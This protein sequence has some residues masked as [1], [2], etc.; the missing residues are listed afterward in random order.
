M[1]GHEVDTSVCMC[2]YVSVCVCDRVTV[3]IGSRMIIMTV[4]TV[5]GD[6][7]CVSVHSLIDG[8]SRF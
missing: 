7:E 2:M 4:I 6:A 8:N 3:T 1:P 5:A